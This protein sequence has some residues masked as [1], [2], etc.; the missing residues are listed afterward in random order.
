MTNEPGGMRRRSQQQPRNLT[1]KVSLSG[2]EKEALQSAAARR[3]KALAAY[4]AETALA[5]AEGRVVPVNDLEREVLRELIRVTG[6]LMDSHG[7][8][9]EAMARQETA[10]TDI[11]ALEAAAAAIGQRATAAQDVMFKVAKLLPRRAR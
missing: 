7:R 3:H 4:V 9:M 2:A 10:G 5:A 11:S 1:V 8:L 6:A